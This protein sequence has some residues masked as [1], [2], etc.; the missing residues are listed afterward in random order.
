[1]IIFFCI[2]TIKACKVPYELQNL[3]P[4][5]GERLEI[6]M[7]KFISGNNLTYYL[8]THQQGIMVQNLIKVKQVQK[9]KPSLNIDMKTN[10]KMPL[11]Q[12]QKINIS[13]NMECF[14]IT[15]TE[16]Y[17]II[18]DCQQ[19]Q[20]LFLFTLKDSQLIQ[21]YTQNSTTPNQTKISTIVTN[22]QT[23]IIYGQFLIKNNKDLS[24]TIL[25][26]TVLYEQEKDSFINTHNLQ[27]NSSNFF[28]SQRNSTN[29]TIFIQLQRNILS[30]VLSEDKMLILTK[31][32]SFYYEIIKM[33]YY[34]S[35]DRCFYSDTLDIQ[36]FYSK[37][38]P[39]L[40]SISEN[41]YIQI[42][43]SKQFIVIYNNCLI[44]LIKYYFINLRQKIFN[45]VIYLDKFNEELF[46]F[47]QDIRIFKLVVLFLSLAS[48]ENNGNFTIQ[49]LEVYDHFKIKLCKVLI[50]YTYLNELDSNIYLKYQYEQQSY[51]N[52][53]QFP[54]VYWITHLS[55]PLVQV[56]VN[57][58]NPQLGNFS[59]KTLLNDNQQLQQKQKYYMVKAFSVN[60]FQECKTKNFS[61]IFVVAVSAQTIDIY[62][63]G[64]LQP[65]SSTDIGQMKINVTQIEIT[66]VVLNRQFYFIIC[67]SFGQNIIYIYQ[68]DSKLFKINNIILNT[69]PFQQFQL[70]TNAVVLLLNTNQI[71]ITTFDNKSLI[72]FNFQIFQEISIDAIKLNLI[73]IFI[74]QQYQSRVLYINNKNSFI[75]GYIMEQFKFLLISIQLVI[76]EI[77]NLQV[78]NSLLIISWIPQSEKVVNFDVWNVYNATN[79]R[80]QGRMRSINYELDKM[81]INY[82]SDNLFY[83]VQI[84]LNLNVYNPNLPQHSSL[85][86][87]ILF[88][89]LY[90]T[91]IA[92]D[93]LAFLCFNQSFY[94]LSPILIQTFQNNTLHQNFFTLQIFNLTFYSQ[95][96][97]SKS[98]HEGNNSV[99]IIYDYLYIDFNQTLINVNKFQYHVEIFRNNISFSGQA[100]Q[101]II[102]NKSQYVTYNL[103]NNIGNPQN[104]NQNTVYNQI[105]QYN[106]TQFFL[107]NNSAILNY[108]SNYSRNF[109]YYNACLASATQDLT[110][111]AFCQDR[112]SHYQIISM[113]LSNLQNDIIPNQ[114]INLTNFSYKQNVWIRIQND[115][116]YIWDGCQ[117]IFH[118]FSQITVVRSIYL[119]KYLIWILDHSIIIYVYF[120]L[121]HKDKLFYKF[122]DRFSKVN[123]EIENFILLESITQQFYSF[124]T[125]PRIVRKK[126]EI[127]IMISNPNFN[128]VVSFLLVINKYNIAASQILFQSIIQT[129]PPFEKHNFT[130]SQLP[131]YDQ[132][133][134]LFM[135][136]NKSDINNQ[137]HMIIYYNISDYSNPNHLT[138]LLF[139]GGYNFT[140]NQT[141]VNDFSF[142][143]YNNSCGQI[144]ILTNNGSTLQL[145]L[146]I[147][148]IK[149]NLTDLRKN[150]TLNLKAYNFSNS[151]SAEII[152]KN[153]RSKAYLKVYPFISCLELQLLFY[154]HL[155]LFII[156]NKKIIKKKKLIRK[157]NYDQSKYYDYY[158]YYYY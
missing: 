41:Q 142:I 82:Y 14:S 120:T 106:K 60:L 129:S 118:Q 43:I 95:F 108:S 19:N 27:E 102:T 33:A 97:H 42:L 63:E 156:I 85:Y 100:L 90:F 65:F 1:M 10:G 84:G 107:M 92:I 15:Y 72:F 29:Q 137:Q 55:G 26:L 154:Q 17:N 25:N 39:I 31:N 52:L 16:F 83:Y 28:A 66:F 4:T 93:Q 18:L 77:Q 11:Q 114:I 8:Q 143:A 40:Q 94:L 138:P 53:L 57:V 74:N 7:D 105:I 121:I 116:L 131:Q 119:Q 101:F 87:R 76:Y 13:S 141:L 128:L 21:I 155:H 73:N 103:T 62:Q 20:T 125:I 158:Y 115:Q 126:K 134:L 46:I 132:G 89:G 58:S 30:Y 69:E 71:A 67:L 109:G 75:I 151:G 64:K 78:V 36:I 6:T 9:N 70:L 80:N 140:L 150:S 34:Y 49:G 110:I 145:Q 79:S 68:Y 147:F 32:M 148:S 113:D 47:G 88:D 3:Y 59:D 23:Y 50:N 2:I 146:N 91:S 38:Q 35:Q 157:M 135:Y 51:Y 153:E 96:N 122:V 99:T 45:T 117:T 98:I 86:Q 5:K 111:Y 123:N 124:E 152:V 24:W 133:L 104:Q 127:I 61:C 48:N 12:L 81:Y 54:F 136:S 130:I 139:Q 144:L 37:Q 149:I 56:I 112:Q 22:Q 44:N